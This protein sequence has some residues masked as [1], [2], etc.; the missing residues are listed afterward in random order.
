MERAASELGY[1]LNRTAR[2][3]AAGQSATAG[4]SESIGVVVLEPTSDF[5]G[6]PK[7]S[8]LLAGIG[9]E[10]SARNLHLVLFAPQSPTDIS[11]LQQY[12]GGGHVDAVL[13]LA[14]RDP[15]WL[16]SRLTIPGIPV[17]FGSRPT[18]HV[19]SSFVEIDNRAGG[20]LATQHL[21]EQGR[22]NIAHIGGSLHVREMHDRLQG[23]RAATWQAGLR[24]DL[25]EHGDS[26]REGGEMAMARLLARGERIDAVFAATDAM[27]VG[28]LWVL[29]VVGRRVPDDVAVIGFDDLPVASATRPALS[30]VRQPFEEMGREMSRAVVNLLADGGSGPRQV[31]LSP[32]LTPRES[33]LFATA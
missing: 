16:R 9:E 11:R 26:D 22:R 19:R 33:T 7:F 29:Q 14:N 13:M 4:R 1:V 2:S 23:F 31:T 8:R 27:A 25:V 3:L 17:V 28:A 5:F 32:E 20:R 21:I 18:D 6:D 12:L 15:D 10:L 30:S 24:C